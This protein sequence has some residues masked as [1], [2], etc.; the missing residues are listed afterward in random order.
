MPGKSKDNKAN[1]GKKALENEWELAVAAANQGERLIA[2]TE[3]VETLKQLR[4]KGGPGSTNYIQ[5]RPG[6]SAKERAR[7]FAEAQG[8]SKDDEPSEESKDSMSSVTKSIEGVAID[9]EMDEETKKKNILKAK[10]KA[11]KEAKQAFEKKEKEEIERRRQ[12]KLKKDEEDRR[13]REEEEKL[14]A[15]LKAEVLAE[16]QKAQLR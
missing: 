6:A 11:E 7:A 13:L 5:Q 2:S 16:K 14:D 10:K 15:V 3:N 12:E 4:G 1:K 8:E 9:E